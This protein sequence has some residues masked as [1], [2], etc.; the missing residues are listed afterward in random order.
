MYDQAFH[1]IKYL[2]SQ[3]TNA[4]IPG[5]LFNERVDNLFRG[6]FGGGI[7]GRGHLLNLP[8]NFRLKIK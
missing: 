1:T 6:R 7:R 2:A 8:R 4:K 5:S 3:L